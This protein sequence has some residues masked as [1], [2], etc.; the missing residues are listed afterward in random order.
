MT[1]LLMEDHCPAVF[2]SNCPNTLTW[3]LLGLCSTSNGDVLPSLTPPF[4]G[5]GCMLL[6]MLSPSPWTWF[7]IYNF[8][9]LWLYLNIA[10]FLILDLL[11]L[12]KSKGQVS[13]HTKFHYPLDEVERT[14]KRHQGLSDSLEKIIKAR[15]KCNLVILRIQRLAGSG[16][17]N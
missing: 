8:F 14:S 12:P 13:D 17:F 9:S 1:V 15:R 7:S 3:M 4:F 5:L 6:L 2:S 11:L 16:V 10:L